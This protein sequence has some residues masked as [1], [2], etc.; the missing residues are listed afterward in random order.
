MTSCSRT[1][2]SKP[3]KRPSAG[4]AGRVSPCYARAAAYHASRRDLGAGKS[5]PDH[6]GEIL[7]LHARNECDPVD[8]EHLSLAGGGRR[9]QERE[10][11]KRRDRKRS[12]LLHPHRPPPRESGTKRRTT[13]WSSSPSHTAQ[14]Q[15][16]H[17]A[18][19]FARHSRR[20][21]SEEF[22]A[23][24]PACSSRSLWPSMAALP[25]RTRAASTTKNGRGNGGVPQGS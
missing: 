12:T 3:K 22:N 13:A 25:E 11:R 6:N 14:G 19:P 4:T 10:H 21:P 20:F 8:P 23:K 7:P 18:R 5:A 15:A 16:A 9:L 24:T 2:K 1:N 17:R